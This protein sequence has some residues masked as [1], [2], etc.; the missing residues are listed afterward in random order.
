[1]RAD[2]IYTVGILNDSEIAKLA[3]RQV[4]ADS[5]TVIVINFDDLR[6]SKVVPIARFAAMQTPSDDWKTVAPILPIRLKRAAGD[7]CVLSNFDSP[8]SI[9]LVIERTAV[10]VAVHNIAKEMKRY[11][12]WLGRSSMTSLNENTD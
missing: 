11:D 12:L 1:M 7:S 2:A 8:R 5:V 4:S 9:R 3:R 6:L 10:D